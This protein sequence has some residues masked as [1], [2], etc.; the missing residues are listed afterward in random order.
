MDGTT[1]R[2]A[3]SLAIAGAS[4][5]ALLAWGQAFDGAHTRRAA[6]AIPPPGP[7]L[8]EIRVDGVARRY[9]LDA[10]RAGPE[11]P[12]GLVIAFH[13]L[14][15][16]AA[17]QA[18]LS[19]LS[20]IAGARGYAVAYPEGLERRWAVGTRAQGAAE[21]GFIRVLVEDVARRHPLDRARV[22]A[23]GISNGAQMAMRL[24]CSAPDLVASVALVAGGYPTRADCP[25]G[26]PRAALFFHGTADRVLPYEGRGALLM[27]VR[28]W[29]AGWAARNGCAAAPRPLLARADVAAESWGSCRGDTE[30]ALYTIAGGG[31][32]WPGSTTMPGKVTRTIS[33]SALMLDFFAAHPRR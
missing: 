23:T 4:L 25:P 5:A 15:G 30:V 6:T 9:L 10:P 24:V 26:P 7:T 28:D 16:S 27:P 2:I 31:H 29:A 21:I 32:A 22:H 3:A 8:H 17:Q 18:Q 33:A 12:I 20:A 14:H 13:G 1:L 19:G 11:G